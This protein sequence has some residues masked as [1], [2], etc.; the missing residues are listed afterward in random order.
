VSTRAPEAPG[1]RRTGRAGAAWWLA[2][3]A[4]GT[5]VVVLLAVWQ[6]RAYVDYSDGVYA[7]S[8]RLVLHGHTPYRDF[9]AAQPPGVYLAGAAVL[10]FGDSVLALRHGLAVVDLILAGLVAAVVLRVT[11]RRTV[12]AGAGLV[13]LLSP[14]ALL[15]HA[16]LLPETFGAPLLA[17][18]ILAAGRLRGCVLAGVLGGIACAFKIAFALPAVAIAAAAAAP[19]A[20][21]AALGAT[22]ATELVASGIG[23]GS[24]FWRQVLQ[25]QSQ[26]GLGGLHYSGGLLFQALWNLLPLLVPAGLAVR[27]RPRGPLDPQFRVLVVGALAS[28][29]LLLSV[30]KQGSYLN[31][32][33]AVEPPLV[34]L[35]ACGWAWAL[36]PGALRSGSPAVLAM[37][38]AAALGMAE[39]ASLL[40]APRSAALLGRPFAASGPGWQ[41]TGGQVDGAVRAAAR[42]PRGSA[43]SGPPYLAFAAQR[44]TPGDQPDQFIITHARA[45]ARFL[46]R[47]DADRER[48]G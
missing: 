47:A 34:M 9:A 37:I 33:V 15:D 16:Q 11:G 7:A 39:T 30:F 27:L 23:F 46:A 43:Y 32:A 41:L 22:L 45:D 19:G 5:L 1:E 10:A 2:A 28:L 8:A 17:G 38:V 29:G 4:T 24:G 44:R 25:A 12:A 3:A 31:V 14:W 13:S 20:A 42:C 21:L 36:V 18:S 26:T 48:C 35:A 6:G 40:A